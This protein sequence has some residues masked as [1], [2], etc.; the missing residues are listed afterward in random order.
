MRSTKTSIAIG[1]AY[2]NAEI[3]ALKAAHRAKHH[4]IVMLET[5][6]GQLKPYFHAF[7]QAAAYALFEVL[8]KAGKRAMY[9]PIN[10]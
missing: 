4:R 3:E 8:K 10:I 1:A 6:S 7:D 9:K 5:Q 2:Y